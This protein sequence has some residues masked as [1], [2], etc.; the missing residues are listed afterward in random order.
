MRQSDG[1]K[2]SVKVGGEVEKSGRGSDTKIQSHS[3]LW[4]RA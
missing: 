4:W 1:W 3:T 2:S